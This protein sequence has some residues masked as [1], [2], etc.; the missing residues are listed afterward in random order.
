M[1]I[2]NRPPGYPNEVRLEIEYYGVHF[3]Y[4]IDIKLRMRYT[5]TKSCIRAPKRHKSRSS[6][7]TPSLRLAMLPIYKQYPNSS[8]I[9]ALSLHLSFCFMSASSGCVMTEII[10]AGLR[11]ARLEVAK[12]ADLMS[13]TS[14]A[15]MEMSP[16]VRRAGINF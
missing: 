8:F 2:F 5:L 11:P 16:I 3:E 15:W 14:V 10:P 13:S 12:K 1:K 4:L 7:I 9:L 6:F